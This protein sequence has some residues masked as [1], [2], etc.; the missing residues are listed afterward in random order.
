MEALHTTET[1]MNN[2]EITCW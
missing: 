1:F 2:Y